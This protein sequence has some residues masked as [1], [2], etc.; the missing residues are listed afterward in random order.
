MWWLGYESAVHTTCP[1]TPSSQ[2]WGLLLAQYY[3]YRTLFSRHPLALSDMQLTSLLKFC[4]WRL[5]ENIGFSIFVSNLGPS[6]ALDDWHFIPIIDTL[7]E[8]AG[9]GIRTHILLHVHKGS[10][11]TSVPLR[12]E[13][14]LPYVYAL[15][16]IVHKF[17]PIIGIWIPKCPNE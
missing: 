13:S 9:T 14:Q 1:S 15:I 8:A 2:M 6:Q 16:F 7:A 12:Q 3:E 17:G 11:Q 5:F 4:W 10:R